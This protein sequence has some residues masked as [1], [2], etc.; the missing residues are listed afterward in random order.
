MVNRPK[1]IREPIGALRRVGRRA[2]AQSH[3]VRGIR[4]RAFATR[5]PLRIP[6]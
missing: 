4:T 3:M 1:Q 2:S 6:N 5:A